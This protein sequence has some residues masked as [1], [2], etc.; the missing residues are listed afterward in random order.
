MLFAVLSSGNSSCNLG[1]LF[2][3]DG[4]RR[5]SALLT[6]LCGEREGTSRY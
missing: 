3:V 2:L 6:E 5:G 1:V 4:V